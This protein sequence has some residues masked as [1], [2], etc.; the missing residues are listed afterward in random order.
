KDIQTLDNALENTL[1]LR[2]VSYTW[3]TDESNVAPQIGVIAQEVEEVYPEF[4]RTDSEGMKSVNYAQMTAV[5][6]EAVKTL[7]AEIESLKKENNQLQAQVDKTEDLERRLAQIEQ[8]LKSGTNS[9]V[10]MNTT[11]D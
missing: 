5:L 2:G 7:N 11:D 10:K 3:K 9:S 1:K 4:V 6:I 8:M